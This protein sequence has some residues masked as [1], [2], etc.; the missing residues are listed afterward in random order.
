MWR[1]L[2]RNESHLIKISLDLYH[3]ALTGV[4][5][6]Q[7]L[8]LYLNQQVLKNTSVGATLKMNLNVA[9]PCNYKN[10]REQEDF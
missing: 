3:K 8:A 2:R 7:N 4:Y 1:S 6:K 9:Y 5:Y 10:L